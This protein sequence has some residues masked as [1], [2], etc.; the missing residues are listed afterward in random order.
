MTDSTCSG[1]VKDEVE[2]RDQHKYT[3]NWN[4]LEYSEIMREVDTSKYE[5]TT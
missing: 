1:Q 5:I 3:V 4:I 2:I